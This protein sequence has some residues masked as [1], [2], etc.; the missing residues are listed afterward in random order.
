MSGH[1]DPQG[2]EGLHT[3]APLNRA[4]VGGRGHFWVTGRGGGWGPWVEVG[5]R[6]TVNDQDRG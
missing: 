1:P 2:S 6:A 3:T 4:A 5:K